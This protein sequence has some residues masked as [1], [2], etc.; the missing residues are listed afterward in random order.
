[1][2]SYI[3]QKPLKQDA[4]GSDALSTRLQARRAE[5]EQAIFTRVQ[6]IADAA[7]IAER[8]DTERLRE[9][10]PAA[11]AYGLAAIERGR[12]GRAPP[13][14]P[15]LLVQSR[16]AARSGVSLDT[17][18]RRYCAGNTLFSD[19]MIEQA[20]QAGLSQEE[21]KRFYRILAASFEHLIATVS[22]EYS[23]EADALYQSAEQRRV[24]VLRRLL[25]GELLG[26]S[27]LSY[28]LGEHH[29]G[30]VAS[31]PEA[32][33]ALRDFSE[34]LD[35]R[36]LLAQPD[37]QACWAW[38]G[39]RREFKAAEL[40]SLA[41]FGWPRQTALACGEPAAGL[42]GWRQ[43]HRQALAAL[44]IAARGGTPFVRYVEVALLATALQDDLLLDSLRQLYLEPLARERDGGKTARETLRAYFAATGNVSSAAAAL[45]VNRRTVS[46]RLAAIEEL[47]GRPLAAASAEIET[48]LR[49]E[50]LGEP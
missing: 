3:P 37:E 2:D 50:A 42:A 49:L 30:I 32:A 5:L 4:S 27:E 33:P 23:R 38:L 41:G 13:V 8:H 19:L 9:A 7:P 6:G 44:P 46:S 21:L 10:V 26:A 48:A 14:P 47:I 1:M 25:A 29:L 28:D 43:T 40:D 45:G 31:G 16:L 11:I 22:E 34:R 35:R 17:V 18:L 39:G 12:E 15:Q 36:L 24:E 20:Q